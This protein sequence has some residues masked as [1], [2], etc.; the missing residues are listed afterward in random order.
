MA[1]ARDAACVRAAGRTN[2]AALDLAQ[3]LLKRLLDD[4]FHALYHLTAK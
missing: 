4:L 3:F 1:A 2:R